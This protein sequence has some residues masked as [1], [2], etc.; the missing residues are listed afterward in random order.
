[1]LISPIIK[2][3]NKGPNFLPCGTPDGI[4][5]Y[6]DMHS[7]P[8]IF[9]EIDDSAQ[10]IL[11]DIQGHC[12][13]SEDCTVYQIEGLSVVKQYDSDNRACPV[14]LFRPRVIHAE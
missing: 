3:N 6:L 13:T 11:W 9:K 8:A 14:S 12:F 2:I 10:N 5:L 4:F 7:L 1:M